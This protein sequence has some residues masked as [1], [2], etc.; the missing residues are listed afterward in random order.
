MRVIRD[1]RASFE[2]IELLAKPLFAHL[3]TAF[4]EGARD[5]P[6]WFLWEDHALWIIGEKRINTF[7]DRIEAEPRV[8]VGVAD[9]DVSTGRVW[10]VGIWGRASIRPWDLLRA[11]R[12][13]VLYL[14]EDVSRWD[15][16]RFV[17]NLRPRD[18]LVWVRVD[19]ETMVARDQSYSPPSSA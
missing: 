9:F 10:H 4:P 17:S 6:V 13:L 12:L 3:A 18:D 2:P 19:P 5:S 11:R 1:R 8:A 15:Q 16:E 14:S 7:I